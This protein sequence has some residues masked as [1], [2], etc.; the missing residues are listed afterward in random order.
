MLSI[1][2]VAPIVFE[3][4]SFSSCQFIL[5]EIVVYA[6][7]GRLYSAY[8][9]SGLNYH[10]VAAAISPERFSRKLYLN[11]IAPDNI[12]DFESDDSSHQ[13]I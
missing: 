11:P 9:R 4:E 6:F 8:C 1:W 3:S 5:E 12:P 13:V 7:A 10:L 2:S